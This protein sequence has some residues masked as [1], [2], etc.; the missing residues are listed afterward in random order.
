[1][2]VRLV[3]LGDLAARGID[4]HQLVDVGDVELT[5]VEGQPLGRVEALDPRLLDHLARGRQLADVAVAV[6]RGD[7]AV[8]AGDVEGAVTRIEH[9][10]FRRI[11]AVDLPRLGRLGSA[12]AGRE[13]HAAA[14]C[15][16]DRPHP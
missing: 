1:M 6:G 7:L 2:P 3:A 4:H 15:G 12:S 13:S 16:G 10:G 9:G 8:D 5:V 14:E 11:K